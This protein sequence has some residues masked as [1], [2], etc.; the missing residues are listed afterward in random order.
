MPIQ[1]IHTT[2]K[3]LRPLG[4]KVRD[5]SQDIFDRAYGRDAAMRVFAV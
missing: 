4:Q 3:Y 5:A 1:A 2:A